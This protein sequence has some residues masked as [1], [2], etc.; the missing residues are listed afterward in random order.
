[1]ILVFCIYTAVNRF[2]G[3]YLVALSKGTTVASSHA[4][5]GRPGWCFLQI[6]FCKVGVVIHRHKGRLGRVLA[7]IILYRGGRNGSTFTLCCSIK[8]LGE[9]EYTA[10]RR[11]MWHHILNARYLPYYLIDQQHP[12][13]SPDNLHHSIKA[14]G[15]RI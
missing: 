8:A 7:R 9:L 14:S 11:C 10:P 12:H 13:S 1:M 6:A 4:A 2:F 15:V 5:L 3:A